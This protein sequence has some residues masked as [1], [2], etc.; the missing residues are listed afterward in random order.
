MAQM[1]GYLPNKHWALHSTP[2]PPKR[3]K[4]YITNNPLSHKFDPK[5]TV[6]SIFILELEKALL[7]DFF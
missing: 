4:N 1:I 7:S 6:A 2:V 5:F 3:Y